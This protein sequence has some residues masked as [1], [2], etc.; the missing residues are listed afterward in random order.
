M[1]RS[2]WSK[3]RLA[4]MQSGQTF[5]V[6]LEPRGSRYQ[7]VALDQ[8][9]MPESE[10]LPPDDPDA[11][12][13]PADI[14]RL[15]SNRL[16]KGVVFASADVSNSNQV[17]ATMGSSE[18]GPWSEPILF[19]ADGTTSDASVLL[20]NEIGQT[21]RVTMRGLTGISSASDVSREAVQ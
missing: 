11:E 17:T 19:R 3:A 7:I 20:Q 1:L 8:L 9:G 4:A 5:V 14:L 13:S 12:H 16:P 21:I 2:A 15:S 18:G 6:R 10:N